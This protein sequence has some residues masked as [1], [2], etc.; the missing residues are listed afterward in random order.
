ME[1]LAHAIHRADWLALAISCVVGLAGVLGTFSLRR[2]LAGSSA[3]ANAVTLFA[4]LAVVGFERAAYTEASS[5]L[6]EAVIRR[7]MQPSALKY[8]GSPA[9]EAWHRAAQIQVHDVAYLYPIESP[10]PSW[11]PLSAAVLVV[12]AGAFGGA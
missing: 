8:L 2:V 3:T 12:I 7:E 6:V 11:A 5:M 4:L 9:N 1:H 10:Y